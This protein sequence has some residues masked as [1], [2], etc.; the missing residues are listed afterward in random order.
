[1][2]A[3]AG[4]SP[5]FPARREAF[6][7]SRRERKGQP[8]WIERCTLSASSRRRC[9]GSRLGID[10]ATLATA[11]L[12]STRKPLSA[13]RRA[14]KWR[15]SSCATSSGISRSSAWP[16]AS[17][18]VAGSSSR[19][20]LRGG[21]SHAAAVNG[22]GFRPSARSSAS[23]GLSAS[24]KRR[25]S[26]RRGTPASAPMVLSPSRSRVRVACGEAAAPQPK[27]GGL[28]RG[29]DPHPSPLWA[30]T[31][32]ARGRGFG[33]GLLCEPRQRP[34]RAR[35]AATAVLVVSPSAANR[36]YI[37]DQRRF[38][39]EQMRDAGDVEPEPVVPST[40]TMA[41]TCR[42]ARQPFDQRGIAGGVGRIATRPGS[43]ARASAAARRP[44]RRAV[45]GFCHRRI[46]GP[47]APSIV[48]TT[49][50]SGGQSGP[51]VLRQ[52]WIARCGHQMERIRCFSC[53]PFISDAPL[54]GR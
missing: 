4:S 28:L 53:A 32:P 5:N 51:A 11:V 38:A 13:S 23:T 12:P 50:A 36:P 29:L 19:R 48:S 1:M 15:R 40:S 42:P 45:P 33:E 21:G 31:S 2:Y 52:R 27:R 39:A 6:G 8:N 3:T 37:R 18:W 44:A 20:M 47:C 10:V 54:P 41:T 14:P 9:L 22:S 35:V 24:R 17:G 16:A 30:P 26:A 25:A 7:P 43:S 34:L 46:T 49:G